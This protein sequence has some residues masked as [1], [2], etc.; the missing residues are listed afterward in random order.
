M[1]YLLYLTFSNLKG[2]ILSLDI[3]L[4]NI[5]KPRKPKKLKIYLYKKLGDKIDKKADIDNHSHKISTI[6]CY[7]KKKKKN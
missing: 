3:L 7:N 5:F 6:S 4:S 2:L 1:L